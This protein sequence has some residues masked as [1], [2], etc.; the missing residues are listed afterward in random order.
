MSHAVAVSSGV[1]YQKFLDKNFKQYLTVC[2][3]GVRHV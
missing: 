1:E 2:S 3:T